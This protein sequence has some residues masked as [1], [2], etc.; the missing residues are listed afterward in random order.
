MKGFIVVLAALLSFQAYSS[1]LID[2]NK[3]LISEFYF[4]QTKRADELSQKVRVTKFNRLSRILTPDATATYNDKTN[5]MALNESLL[6][7]NGK[8]YLVKNVQEILTP[9]YSGFSPVATIFHEMAHAEIDIFIENNNEIS[10]IALHY[11]Y[12]TKLRPLYRKYFKGI[13]PWTIFH[14]H[15]SYY[16]TDLMEAIALDIMDIHMENGWVANEKRCYLN[17]Y[18]RNLLANGVSF[19]NFSKVTTQHN[20]SY[21]KIY[22]TYIFVRGKDLNLNVIKGADRKILDEAHLL[23]WH[24]HREFYGVPSSKIE[25]TQKMDRDMRYQELKSCRKK[26][27]NNY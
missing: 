12:K 25:L 9:N 20:K 27:Y 19:E 3:G 7:R 14:E 4:L 15:F 23:F 21:K 18:L 11:F 2:F 6:K 1:S 16:R 10:D 26:F 13:N 17:S 8:R 24:Y 5:T 22:P